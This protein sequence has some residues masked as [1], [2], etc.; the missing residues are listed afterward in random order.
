MLIIHGQQGC[1]LLCSRSAEDIIMQV[2]VV[3]VLLTT[4]GDI[5]SVALD[6]D[7]TPPSY[8]SL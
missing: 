7:A 2:L 8:D 4:D 6:M 1:Q 5:I 3:M